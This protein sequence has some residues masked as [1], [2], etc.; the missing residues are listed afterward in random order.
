MTHLFAVDLGQ[1]SLLRVQWMVF[2]CPCQH[3]CEWVHWASEAAAIEANCGGLGVVV[4]QVVVMYGLHE[5]PRLAVF[6][7]PC[8]R[9]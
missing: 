2:C 7:R 1:E 8:S 5:M 3:Q 9:P 4:W 6:L